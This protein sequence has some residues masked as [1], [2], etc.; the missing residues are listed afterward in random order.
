M[1]TSSTAHPERMRAGLHRPFRNGKHA[2][3]ISYGKDA[4]EAGSFEVVEHEARIVWEIIA[5][6]AGGASLYSEAV[7]LNHRGELSPGQKYRDRPWTYGPRWAQSTVRKMI[8]QM[9][10]AGTHTVD[11]GAVPVERG[12]P[13]IVDPALREQAL[14]GLEENKRYTSGKPGRCTF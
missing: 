14:T 5:N 7:R 1:V 8:V 3:R 9:T 4:N 13:A 11:T 12:S 2:G 6:V 10:R